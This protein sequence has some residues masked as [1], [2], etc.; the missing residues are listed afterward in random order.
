MAIWALIGLGNPGPKYSLTRHNFGFLVVDLIHD[1]LNAN[2]FV[3]KQKSLIAD[4]QPSWQSASPPERLIFIKPQTFMNLSGQ[5]AAPILSFYKIPL[6]NVIV[7]HDDLDLEL[8]QVKI[9][10]GGSAGGHNG[11]KSLDACIGKEYWRIR[12]GISHPGHKDAVSDY[13]LSPFTKIE[14]DDIIPSILNVCL[15]GTL[16]FLQEGGDLSAWNRSLQDHTR[17]GKPL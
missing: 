4:C 9:K 15:K 2:A 10:R 14:Q 13:V 11:L 1:V 5:G 17:Q 12:I 8:G 3:H 7:F 16:A 6:E